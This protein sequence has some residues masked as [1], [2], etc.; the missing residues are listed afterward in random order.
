[1]S[2]FVVFLAL[3]VVVVVIVIS[4]IVV[5]VVVAAAFAQTLNL[6]RR[7]YY[8]LLAPNCCFTFLNFEHLSPEFQHVWVTR[9][10]ES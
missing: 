5:V 9:A 10:P 2:H 1:M 3:V 7:S 8:T 4:V 6:C